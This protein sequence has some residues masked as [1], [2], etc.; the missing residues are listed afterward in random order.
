MGLASK[1]NTFSKNRFAAAVSR[2]RPNYVDDSLG[3][4]RSPA[5]DVDLHLYEAFAHM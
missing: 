3:A 1:L 5:F 4:L 2:F